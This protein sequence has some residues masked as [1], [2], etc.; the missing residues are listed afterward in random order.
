MSGLSHAGDDV[1][2][3]EAAIALIGSAV[4]P[5][6]TVTVP[7]AEAE[8]RVLACPPSAPLAQI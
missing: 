8:G 5:L 6:G 1:I 3:F 2:G 7:L 4:G